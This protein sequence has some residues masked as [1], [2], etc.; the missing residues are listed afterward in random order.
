[1]EAEKEFKKKLE[2]IEQQDRK[3]ITPEERSKAFRE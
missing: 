1:M 3:T 2:E